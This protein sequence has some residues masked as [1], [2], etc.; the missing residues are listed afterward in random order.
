[1]LVVIRKKLRVAAFGSCFFGFFR[2]L[3]VQL[4]FDPKFGLDNYGS[5]HSN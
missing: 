5:S 1:L 3:W 4:R 2:V